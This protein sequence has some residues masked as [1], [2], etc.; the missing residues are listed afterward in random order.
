MSRS[1]NVTS[2]FAF[3]FGTC[4]GADVALAAFLCPVSLRLVVEG[5]R[6]PS[7][8]LCRR[9]DDCDAVDAVGS[10]CLSPAAPLLKISLVSSKMS[11]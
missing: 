7:A 11:M 8:E 6:L 9:S 1:P 5:L 10:S 3:V 2:R 4:A